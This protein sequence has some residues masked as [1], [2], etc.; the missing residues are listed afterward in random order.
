[1]RS[2]A[3]SRTW[4][5]KCPWRLGRVSERGLVQDCGDLP[6]PDGRHQQELCPAGRSECHRAHAPAAV[7]PAAENAVLCHPPAAAVGTISGMQA[8]PCGRVPPVLPCTEV[9]QSSCSTCPGRHWINQS[10]CC[11]L[12]LLD[13]VLP[14]AAASRSW[15]ATYLAA[16]ARACAW[17]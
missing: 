10:P 12:L 17:R 16:T 13:Q 3:T 4:W 7:L 1:M 9:L 6:A 5:Q 14:V 15:L 8:T 11:V 2:A